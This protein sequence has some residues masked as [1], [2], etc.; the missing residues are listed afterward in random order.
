VKFGGMFVK[1]RCEIV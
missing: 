1:T